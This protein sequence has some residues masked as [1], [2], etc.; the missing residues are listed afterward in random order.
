MVTK[1]WSNVFKYKRRI[2]KKILKNLIKNSY[3]I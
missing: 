1:S 2:K 3:K